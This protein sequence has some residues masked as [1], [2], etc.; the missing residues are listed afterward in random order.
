MRGIIA[1]NRDWDTVLEREGYLNIFEEKEEID[2]L[3]IDLQILDAKG[4]IVDNNQ[5]LID[6]INKSKEV[7]ISSVHVASIITGNLKHAG[8]NL[9]PNCW[10]NREYKLIHQIHHLD[11]D[12][13][14]LPDNV[15]PI[16]YDLHLNHF[17]SL[18]QQYPYKANYIW[19]RE[20][21]Y[22]N[23]WRMAD[24]PHPDNRTKIFLVPNRY[25][26]HKSREIVKSIIEESP[27]FNGYYSALDRRKM[28]DIDSTKLELLDNYL[29]GM[30]N[31]PLIY[32]HF[33]FIPYE[34]RVKNLITNIPMQAVFNNNNN[35]WIST[36]L[37]HIGYYENTFISVCC[38]S[39]ERDDCI[40][41]EKTLMPLAHGHFVL[42]IGAPGIISAL[43]SKGFLFPDFIDYSYDE[44][45][46]FDLRIKKFGEEFNRLTTLEID[47]WRK[48]HM[49]WINILHHNRQMFFKPYDKLGL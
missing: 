11:V 33:K 19:L 34:N 48:H 3:F 13:L 1:E 8:K 23:V 2:Y 16:F 45:E 6:T 27:L 26:L 42:P 25:G 18:I 43:K 30:L 49:I 12:S 35:H 44:V 24:M 38:E 39:V 28:H 20:G 37:V 46:D 41:T 29:F 17:K 21:L 9:I 40:I 5:W 36:N 7:F 14:N 32:N 4:S 10:P 15:T 47:R 22:K 31:D